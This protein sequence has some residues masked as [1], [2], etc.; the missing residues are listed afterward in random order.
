MT[1]VLP[2]I[3]TQK[4]SDVL[5]AELRTRIVNGIYSI[6]DL[7]PA[8]RALSETCQVSRTTVREALRIL[9]VQELIHI[10][11]GRSGGAVVRHPSTQLVADSLDMLIRSRKIALAELLD[12]RKAIEPS[13]ARLAALHRT[14]EDVAALNDAQQHLMNT[15]DGTHLEFNR[16]NLD[17]HSAVTRASHNR[18]LISMMHALSPAIY[19][20]TE[21]ESVLTQDVRRSVAKIH[22]KITDSIV[23]Q[24]ADEAE[25]RMTAHVA[26]AAAELEEFLV[27]ETQ[28]EDGSTE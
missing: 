25:R 17:W 14:D 28:S 3:K 15:I 9:E 12:A 4:A 22:N 13:S 8:E 6:G 27:E 16:A 23:G 24:R 11:T 7:L 20:S 1:G 18:I 19:R 26:A 2:L 10:R 5:A 21:M